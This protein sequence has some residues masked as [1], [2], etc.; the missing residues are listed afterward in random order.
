MKIQYFLPFFLL[1]LLISFS[2][3]AVFCENK[4]G[5]E[6]EIK[7]KSAEK[8]L[9]TLQEHIENL[10][11]ENALLTHKLRE[12]DNLIK[13]LETQIEKGSQHSSVSSSSDVPSEMARKKLQMLLEKIQSKLERLKAIK[14][15]LWEELQQKNK[16]IEELKSNIL[17]GNAGIKGEAFTLRRE[18]TKTQDKL[19][20]IQNELTL[21]IEEKQNYK[22]LIQDLTEKIN[23]KN[24]EIQDLQE[25]L[26]TTSLELSELKRKSQEVARTRKLNREL[27]KQL[28]AKE[29]E[30]K[31]TKK[32]FAEARE[33]H[34]K[35]K[36]QYLQAI[37]SKDNEI[38]R[39][40]ERLDKV[41]L[42]KKALEKGQLESKKIK[43]LTETIEN[44]EKEIENWKDKLNLLSQDSEAKI[45]QLK[46]KIEEK[47]K[48][49][50]YLKDII[51]RAL[52]YVNKLKQ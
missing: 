30:I 7:I 35:E 20:K 40:R 24:K 32:L 36:E 31:E 15:S 17:Q 1:S 9:F 19:K 5:E 11:Q 44:K 4:L 13:N 47:N 14:Q 43:E 39:L 48:E 28:K 34:K 2:P 52:K 22:R 16:V 33:R 51:K 10:K 18:I 46:E 3:F 26:Q 6:L 21:A 37:T 49:I 29:K 42:E 27:K 25:R 50:A 8:K 38:E 41:S 12:K 23:G 45:S